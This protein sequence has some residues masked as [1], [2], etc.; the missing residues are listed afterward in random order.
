MV[1]RHTKSVSSCISRFGLSR[2]ISNRK[3]LNAIGLDWIDPISTNPNN[4][5]DL[6]QMALNDLS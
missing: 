4:R 1:T 6:V 5:I 2:K 3:D